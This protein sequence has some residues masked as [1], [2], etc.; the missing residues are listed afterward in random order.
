MKKPFWK[1]KRLFHFTRNH[2]S[3]TYGTRG[4]ALR[5]LFSLLIR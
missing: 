3:Y 5:F 4:A 2:L 1:P